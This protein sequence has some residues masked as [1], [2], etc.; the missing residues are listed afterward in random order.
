MK[1]TYLTILILGII[2]GLFLRDLL[3]DR[4]AAAKV[5]TVRS[6]NLSF[7]METRQQD[8]SHGMTVD[9]VKPV[10]VTI[11]D[12]GQQKAVIT[13]AATVGD[14]LYE[15]G[16]GL[17]STDQINPPLNTFLTDGSTVQIDRIVDLEIE[18][19]NDIPFNI[20]RINDAFLY[21]G[22][23]TVISAGKLGKKQQ[24]F[25]ITYKNGV[26]V[27]RRL[28]S[29]LILEEPVTEL[30]AFGTK[31]EVE[32]YAR[33]R[34]SWY[35]TKDCSPAPRSLGVG[36]CAAHPHYD[37]GRYVRVTRE[38]TGKSIIVE[39]ND[40]GPNQRIHPDRVIDLDATVFRELASLGTGTIAVKIELLKN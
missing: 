12:G 16:I 26:E 22:K 38:D 18:E 36:G 8:L 7:Q 35:A 17:A 30:T 13:Q 29:E 5:V 40:R 21:Y 6:R 31:I 9:V 14:L 32:E 23:E 39:I 11:N 19:V 33:G 10:Q 3:W 27:R 1:K 20:S 24:R 15:Q 4:P 34:A 2:L 37:F 25:L 28:L